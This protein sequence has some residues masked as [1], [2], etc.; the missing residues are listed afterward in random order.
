MAE[1]DLTTLDLE[2]LWHPLT[3]HRGLDQS[4]PLRIESA[5]GCFIVDS[6]GRRYLDGVSGLWC[7]NIGHGR[8]ELA[9]VAREQMERLAYVPL[10]FSHE[11]AIRLASKLVD[12][13]GY[14]GRVYFSNSGS[15]ANE[16]AIKIARQYHAQ[17]GAPPGRVKI[18]ARHRGYHGNTLGALSATG[19]AERRQ[20]YEPLLPGF[21]FVDAPDP[22]RNPGD[23]AAALEEAILRE[24]PETVAGFLMEPIIAGGGV[25]VPDD[26][27]LPKVREICDRHGVLLMLDEVVN[28]FG[29][30]GA[31]FAH[32]HWGVEPD[33]LTLAKGIASGYM[34]LAATVVK[35]HVF[36]AFGGTPGDLSHFRHVNTYGGHPVAT[37]VGLRNVEIIEREDLVSRARETGASIMTRLKGLLDH[38]NVGDVRGKGLL[39]GIELV[40][41]QATKRPLDWKPLAA[42]VRRCLGQ[43]VIIGRNTN[44]SPGLGNV[45]ILAPPLV[46]APD[47]TDLL[48]SALEC[49][50][51]EELPAG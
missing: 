49:A 36:E 6:E 26:A 17:S 24:G 43:G 22:Y 51:Y 46:I 2:S 12:L 1:R 9:E 44:T 16:A 13:L 38:P 28:A 40:E 32:R 41:D 27:Y 29:R 33:I 7:V 3:Q 10:T 47:E 48:L 45:L 8:S 35:S 30:T 14:E 20:G 50:L 19:Q 11:P 4:P 42:I 25:L 37:A 23:A 34:P 18:I 15:E 31:M 21:L 39:I 5:S